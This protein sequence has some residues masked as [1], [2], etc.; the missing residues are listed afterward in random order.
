MYGN[1]EPFLV[2]TLRVPAYHVDY[3][4]LQPRDETTLPPRERRGA[5]GKGRRRRRDILN[6]A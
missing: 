1:C 4:L 2:V 6:A 5:A 3:T